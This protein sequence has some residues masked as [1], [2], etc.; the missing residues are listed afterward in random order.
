MQLIDISDK[1]AQ[2]TLMKLSEACHLTYERHFSVCTSKQLFLVLVDDPSVLA[3]LEQSGIDLKGLKEAVAAEQMASAHPIRITKG[4][5]VFSPDLKQTLLN[6]Y[7]ISKQFGREQVLVE[8][9]FFATIFSTEIEKIAKDLAVD[10]SPLEY[11]SGKNEYQDTQSYKDQGDYYLKQISIDL[12]DKARNGE[13]EIVVGRDAELIQLSR[14]LV[15]QKDNNVLLIGEVG[16]GKSSIVHSLT[17]GVVNSLLGNLLKDCK[18]LEFSISALGTLLDYRNIQ[19]VKEQILEDLQKMGKV[20]IYIKNWDLSNK[21]SYGEPNLLLSFIKSLLDQKN[22]RLIISTT[23]STYRNLLTKDPNLSEKFGVVRVN[24]ASV[25]L[26][27]EILKKKTLSLSEFHN[28]TFSDDV[29]EA[30][31][32]LSKRY[33]QDKFLPSKA[34]GLLDEASSKVALENRNLVSVDDLKAIISEKT[35]IPIERLSASEQQKLLNLE[36]ILGQNVIGQKEA[37]H[38]VSEVVRRSRAGLKDPRKPVGTFLFLGPTGVGKTYLAK[39]LTRVVYDNEQAMIRLD[40]SEFSEAH[41]VQRLIG[42]PPGYVGYEEGG[43]L[44]NP[45]WE[46]PY[47]LIL[48]DEIEKA[49]PKVF[50]IFLQV[51]DEGRLT[52]GQGRTIDFKNTIIIATSNIASE[53]ILDGL[54]EEM[55]VDERTMFYDKNILPVLRQYFLPE[56][57]NRFDEVILFN[58][59]TQD[60][61]TEIARLQIKKMQARIQDKKI[62]LEV[63]DEK[64]QELVQKGYKPRFGAR[65]IIRVIQEQIENVIAR[66]IISGEIKEGD[67]VNI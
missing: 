27:E 42:S 14:M 59:L 18:V 57:I 33:I 17:A 61:L 29:I 35:G 64:I 31:A 4:Q 63:S 58:P 10:L 37:V 47:S 26:T 67:V 2:E 46:R 5:V 28:I 12:T 52:D 55:T 25:E 43:Q 20:I 21:D 1:Y 13:L 65:P 41:T 45:V 60:E 22:I 53:F 62:T 38:R 30:C 6:A 15:R 51:L 34:I 36:Q 16:V 9:L 56:F 39:C 40:M 8:D 19:E 7:G 3:L 49:N 66:K 32:S 11:K 48:L 24:E 44:T 23:S 50:D 54:R